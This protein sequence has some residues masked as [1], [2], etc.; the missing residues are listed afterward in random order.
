MVDNTVDPPPYNQLSQ[1]RICTQDGFYIDRITI[2]K[3]R[4]KQIFY[5]LIKLESVRIDVET[6][7]NK[8]S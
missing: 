8:I 7:P 2:R 4:H 1:E 3:G 6:L 5:K